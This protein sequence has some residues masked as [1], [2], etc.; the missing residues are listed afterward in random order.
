MDR[1]HL[2]GL[3][4]DEGGE[5]SGVEGRDTG[6]HAG[7]AVDVVSVIGLV[8][9]HRLSLGLLPLMCG[10]AEVSGVGPAEEVVDHS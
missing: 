8:N 2:E 6:R 9:S 4:R 7:W 10:G 1:E 5:G 3:L